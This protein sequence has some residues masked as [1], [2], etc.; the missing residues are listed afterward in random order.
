MRFRRPPEGV[1]GSSL[2]FPDGLRAGEGGQRPGEGRSLNENLRQRALAGPLRQSCRPFL[3]LTLLSCP[4]IGFPPS[5]AERILSPVRILIRCQDV[6]SEDVRSEELVMRRADRLFQLIQLLRRKRLTTARKL[7]E[8][9]EVSERTVYRDV[10]DLMLSGV[11]I[12]GEAGVGYSLARGYDLPPL[13]FS[14]EELE[15]LLLGARM[16]K[17]WGD[18]GLA[19]SVEHAIARIEAVLPERLKPPHRMPT[20]FVPEYGVPPAVSQL[21]APLREAIRDNRR[22]GMVYC[23]AQKV[24]SSRVIR[25]VGL[26]FWGAMWSV[27]GW[28]EL[29]QSFR[30]FRLDRISSLELLDVFEPNGGQTLRDF[31]QTVGGLDELS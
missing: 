31:L 22:I 1:S 26:F 8:S 25:P 6:R 28:C 11:P 30:N 2:H 17:S 19:Q 27:A 14:A 29:R 13:M 15:A 23:D 21:L 18:Q 3:A 20:L 10:R 7:A 12:E 16:V 4:Y 24:A 5:A 9:L